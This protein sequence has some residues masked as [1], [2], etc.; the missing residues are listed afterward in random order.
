MGFHCTAKSID[1]MSESCAVLLLG[2]EFGVLL[3]ELCLLSTET[4]PV[5]ENTESKPTLLQLFTTV[6]DGTFHRVIKFCW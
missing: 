2:I 6:N 3:Y 1:G 5:R 4:A